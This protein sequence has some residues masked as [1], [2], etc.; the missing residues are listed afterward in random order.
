MRMH[1]EKSP[2]QKKLSNLSSN[3]FWR[4]IASINNSKVML[5]TSIEDATGAKEIS[6]LWERHFES[7]FNCL[8]NFNK[9]NTKYNVNSSFNEMRVTTDEVIAAIKKIEL[10]K[11]SGADNIHAEHIKYANEKLVPLLSICFTACFVHGFLPS[12]LLT[13]VLVPIVKNKAGNINSID[14]YRPVALSNI[15]SKILEI[16]ILGRIDIF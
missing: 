9:L 13:V 16:I 12:S 8:Q 11:S 4:E 7:I 3:E 5:P 15:F 6:I 2:W 14:N 10:N 1:L